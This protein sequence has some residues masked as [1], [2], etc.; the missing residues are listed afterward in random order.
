MP[1]GDARGHHPDGDRFTQRWRSVR[2][3]SGKRRALCRVVKQ[4]GDGHLIEFARPGDAVVTAVAICRDA[5]T[6]GVRV[7]AGAH[8]GEV[9]RRDGEDLGGL[10]VHIAARVAAVAGPGEVVVSRT[11][12]DLLGSAEHELHD[13]GEHELKGVPG[14][15]QLFNVGG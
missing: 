13:R 7:R 12:V 5:P 1:V 4:T 11:V 14:R 15:W 10:S 6:L 9:E 3:E 2:H 8:T